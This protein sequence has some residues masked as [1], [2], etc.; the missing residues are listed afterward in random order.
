MIMKNFLTTIICSFS[1]IFASCKTEEVTSIHEFVENDNVIMFQRHSKGKG[2]QIVLIADGYED[3]TIPTLY[4][5][6]GHLFAVEPYPALKDYFTVIGIKKVDSLGIVAY[7]DRYNGNKSYISKRV[8]EAANLTSL[9]NTAIVVAVSPALPIQRSCCKMGSDHNEV[10]LSLC[11]YDRVSES[12]RRHVLTH[13]V[14]GHAIGALEDEYEEYA[15]KIP[16]GTIA[17]NERW[18]RKGMYLNVIFSPELPSEWQQLQKAFGNEEVSIY[19]GGGLYETGVYRSSENSIMKTHS[20]RYNAVSEWLIWQAIIAHK[21][22]LKTNIEE[23]IA[24]RKQRSSRSLT[25]DLES[26]AIPD[27]LH[28]VLIKSTE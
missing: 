1:I 11:A 19:E 9:L 28:G 3:Q 13:E 10:T 26:V 15:G 23:F 7:Q 25:D 17:S 2:I 27:S 12:Y 4:N 16:A 14:G 24:Y 5:M 8:K 18:Q 6:Y 21:G 22:G 20:N